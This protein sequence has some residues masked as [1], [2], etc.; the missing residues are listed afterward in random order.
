ML[1]LP[2]SG[3]QVRVPLL[4]GFHESLLLDTQPLGEAESLVAIFSEMI[5]SDAERAWADI[6]VSDGDALLL[7]MRRSVMG[8][9]LQ[10]DV[11][12][13][14]KDCGARIDLAFS[15]AA[16]LNHNAPK[17]AKGAV[18]EAEMWWRLDGVRFR[19][20][21]LSD[22]IEA[23]RAKNAE[24]FLAAKCVDSGSPDRKTRSRIATALGRLA[25]NLAGELAAKCPDCGSSFTVS[26]DPRSFVLRELRGLAAF[27]D[28]DIHLL[29][30]AYHWSYRDILSLPRNRRMQFAERV[31]VSLQGSEA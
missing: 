2:V 25:P 26:F 10:A 31:R 20:P 9:A 21:R 23:R 28:E 30:S 3:W 7:H 17:P 14:R 29:A 5:E 4:T 19:A 1:T 22:E 12:C 15:I 13:T 6:P 8:D 11:R 18:R 24:Q 27:L 16:Y